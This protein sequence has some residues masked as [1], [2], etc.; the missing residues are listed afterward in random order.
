MAKEVKKGAEKVPAKG[1][2][3]ATVKELEKPAKV[4]RIQRFFWRRKIAPNPAEPGAGAPLSVEARA[5]NQGEGILSFPFALYVAM[6]VLAACILVAV[7][8][9][10]MYNHEITKRN[11]F[12]AGVNDISDYVARLY[13]EF[14]KLGD[15]H[16][17]EAAMNL[18]LK[19]A[20]AEQ[21]NKELQ[22]AIDDILQRLKEHW[23]LNNQMLYLFDNM[24]LPRTWHECV[25][26]CVMKTSELISIESKEEEMYVESELIGEGN[27]YW[28]GLYK[29]SKS[30]L[31]IDIN[32]PLNILYWDTTTSQPNNKGYAGPGTKNCVA[33]RANCGNQLKCCLEYGH[34]LLQVSHF[35][36][37]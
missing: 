29:K 4:V 27:D 7:A 12:Q 11:V 34:L 25:D 18:S 20:E 10:F 26:Y 8:M 24:K 22:E 32:N 5:F 23:S 19:V 31:W 17:L 28:I 9:V 30:W 16:R 35:F 37:Q 15:I 33:I 3:T 6:M 13:P 36:F 14:Q 1:T 21:A 2:G